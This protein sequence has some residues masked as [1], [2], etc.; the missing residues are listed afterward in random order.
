MAKPKHLLIGSTRSGSGKSA[1]VLGLA[2]NLQAKGYAVGYGKPLGTFISRHLPDASEQE[3]DVE[4]ITKTLNLP[5][6][7][8]LPTLVQLG[9]ETIAQ[10]LSGADTI[11]YQAELRKYNDYD[12]ADLVL[13]ESTAN[14]AEGAIFGLSL[15]QMSDCLEAPILLVL[16]FTSLLVVD[17]ILVAKQRFGER[18]L[19]VVINDVPEDEYELVSA[20]LRDYLESQQIPILAIT[21]ENRT[22]RS[23]SVSELIDQLGATVLCRPENIDFNKLMIEELKI[24]AMDVNSAQSFFSKS[25][26]KVVITGNGR[27]DLQ[28]AA[29][30]TSTNCLILTGR[31]TVS[32]Q[33]YQKAMELGVPILS[34][35]TDT[36]KTVDI[37]ESCLDQV[38]L[39]EGVKVGIIKDMMQ[40]HFQLERLM[41]LLGL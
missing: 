25:F 28:L 32:E 9:R 37:I 5:K 16:R 27:I 12:H 35:T 38:R 22:L 17:H 20:L 19:G 36:L 40:S 24:G 26:N 6:N 31:P 29:L 33:V 2:F 10:R 34:V 21:P 8:H 23:I 15:E 13:V 7:L 3:V 30:E 11:D 18:L 41:R 14:T 1:S 4:F 39:H